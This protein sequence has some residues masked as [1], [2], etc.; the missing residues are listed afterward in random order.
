MRHLFFIRKG[1]FRKLQML[2]IRISYNVFLYFI[3]SLT[4]QLFSRFRPFVVCNKLWTGSFQNWLFCNW[5]RSSGTFIML[6]WE[7]H[8]YRNPCIYFPLGI[9]AVS[10]IQYLSLAGLEMPVQFHSGHQP[11]QERAETVRTPTFCWYI[12]T[13]PVCPGHLLLWYAGGFTWTEKKMRYFSKTSGMEEWKRT[14]E[15]QESF[16]ES[17]VGTAVGSWPYW[18]GVVGDHSGQ[19]HHWSPF[20]K[21]EVSYYHN[22]GMYT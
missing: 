4:N 5:P 19:I 11:R 17:F 20:F 9:R 10:T 18:S 3:S 22:S 21:V 16:V 15:T 12:S 14:K 2:N 1:C 8:V 6:I 7:A 13:P